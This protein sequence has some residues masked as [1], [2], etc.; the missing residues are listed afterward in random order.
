MDLQ[1]H[2]LNP[3]QRQAV[4]HIG[5]PLLILAG[6]GSGKTRV[7]TQRIGY[8]LEHG[9]APGNILAMSFT[10]KA[11]KEMQERV[12]KTVG[13]KMADRLHL[14]TFHSLGAEILRADIDVLGFKKPFTILDSGDQLNIVREGMKELKLDPKMVDPKRILSIISLA[15]M[16]LA[17]PQSVHELRLDPLLPFAQRIFG[18]YQSALRGLNAVDFDDLICLPVEIF[19]TSEEVRQ[20]YA[21][22]FQYVMVD[23]YQDTNHTQLMFLQE[24]VKD[25]QNIVVV[26]DD[27][28]SIYGFRGAV[29]ENILGFEHKFDNTKVITLEQNYRSTNSILGA[30][31][32]L[33]ANNKVRKDKK[34]W[35]AKGDGEKLRWVSCAS[36]REEAEYVAA[37]IERIKFDLQLEYSDFA[38]LYRV[39]P[40]A[41]LFEEALR[42][43]RIPYTVIGSTE[44]FDRKEVKDFV[45]YLQ[46]CVN[47]NDE[48]NMRRIVNVPPRG[49]GPTLLERISVYA[50]T[51][52]ISFFAA[53]ERIALEP[54]LVHGIG[55]A[56]ST[57]LI[58]FVDVIHTFRE[59][60][61]K[62]DPETA[63]QPL[64]EIGRALLKRTHMVDHILSTDKNPKIARMRIENMEGILA[65]IVSYQEAGG[66]SLDKFLT[67]ITLD[68]AS[69]DDNKAGEGVKLMTFHSS[70]GLEFPV[71]FMVGV[72]E[73][74]LPHARSVDTQEGISEE[75]RLA[76]VGIT[77]AQEYLVLT[78]AA[79]R[80]RYDKKE[81]REPSR[82]LREIPA[83]MLRMEGAE[84]SRSL[85]DKRDAQNSKYLAA[86]RSMLAD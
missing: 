65:S 79:E 40:Q 24:I 4:Q 85:A 36:E 51:E 46:V 75:R 80:S 47:P 45:G 16:A 70:K 74:Y 17:E 81:S 66:T 63:Q 21:K 30:A 34:L 43:F 10:N 53:L 83:S 60:F 73:G 76:Y 48:L 42:S 61:T 35:S 27:D 72:E 57:H 82:F 38:I 50:S 29:A 20:K 23:E 3:Q 62:N 11:A 22:K 13:Q 68:R 84:Q 44:Y 32:T 26:G 56:V 28:Q 14:S 19:K 2:L 7:I 86:L 41:R 37:E 1:L 8:L 25:H 78:T 64:A 69:A 5:G 6:A 67:R 59:R 52:K 39:N 12:A 49:I 54:G 33:I 18:K 31:N 58:D 15:K 77:R 55:H 9:I 71:V